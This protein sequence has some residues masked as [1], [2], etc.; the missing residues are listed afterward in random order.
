MLFSSLLCSV[1]FVSPGLEYSFSHFTSIII[2]H[3]QIS[4]MS[5]TPGGPVTRV[6]SD[7][8]LIGPEQSDLGRDAR[9]GK[10]PTTRHVMK[11]FF[12]RKKPFK[13]GTVVPNCEVNLKCKDS[14]ECVVHKLKDSLWYPYYR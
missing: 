12:Y 2:T 14:S 6:N 10:L 7:H 3:F 1:S 4:T 5:K 8:F 13:S 11:Y 9:Q